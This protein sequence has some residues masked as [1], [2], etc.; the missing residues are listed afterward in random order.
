MQTGEPMRPNIQRAVEKARCDERL[1]L[2]DALALWESN[3]LPMLGSLA[4]RARFQRKPD[5]I[6]TFIA[7]RN[8]NYTN[9]CWV[10]CKFCAF[11][12]LPNSPEGYTLP[13]EEIFQKI[14]EL[15]EAGGYEIL[16]QGGLNPKLRIDYFERLF[17]AIR[18][19]FPTVHIHGLSVAEVMYIAKISK[20]TIRETLQ[21]LQASGMRTVPGAGGEILDDEARQIIA[22]YK[23]TT[24]QWLDVMR[25]AHELGMRSTATMMYGHVETIEHRMKHLI[26]VRELQDETGGFTAFAAWS[27]QPDGTDLPIAKRSSGFEHLKMMALCRLM[28]DNIDNLQASWVTQGPKIA[29]ISLDFGVN[30]FGQTMMEENVV[31]AAGTAFTMDAPEICR[32]IRNAGYTPRLRNAYYEDMGDPDLLPKP[33]RAPLDLPLVN[34]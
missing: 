17:G 14:E 28:L 29:Q 6:V 2:D 20:L 3:D 33:K 32:L 19:R 15:V 13:D 27:F 7:S 31:S 25:T 22:P 30:D 5:N 24:R 18:D 9:I 16:I 21:R 26:R 4:Q 34:A 12:R 1:N 11:Y 8:I 10:Q 23:D